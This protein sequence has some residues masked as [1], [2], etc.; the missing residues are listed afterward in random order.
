MTVAGNV[1]TVGRNEFT[2]CR[3]LKTVILSDNV[4]TIDS[5]AFARSGL[6]SITI[7]ESVTEI[8]GDPFF[9]V[10][11]LVIECAEGS[12]AESYAVENSIM[13]KHPEDSD[14]GE[15]DN[16]GKDNSDI[17][18]DTSSNVPTSVPGTDE[19]P[20][21]KPTVTPAV[22]PSLAPTIT[23]TEHPTPAAS[24]T[25]TSIPEPVKKGTVIT[26]TESKSQVRIVSV[27]GD[28]TSA[29]FIGTSDLKAKNVVIPDTV[30][31]YNMIYKITSVEANAFKKSN[32]TTV[33]LGKNIEKIKPRAF[34]GS[35]VS[36][37][38]IKSSHLT[39]KAVKNAFKGSKAGN[40]VIKVDLGSKK[41]NT[42]YVRKYR[43]IFTKKNIGKKAKVKL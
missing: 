17:K 24:T 32:A 26:D 14:A 36:T 21:T 25:A 30:T 2:D 29:A 12:V 13:I 18:D 27:D 23:N 31:K 34:S 3:N 11:D 35:K 19:I 33:T 6:E 38:I 43:K 28:N 7:P 4:T 1:T 42:K 40:I 37:V 8:N 9:G 22:T 5:W 41:L 15:G 16:D 10:S 39:K 20:D